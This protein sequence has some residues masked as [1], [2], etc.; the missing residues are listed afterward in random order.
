MLHFLSE[1]SDAR[2]YA[3]GGFHTGRAKLAPFFDVAEQEGLE[4]EFIQEE[5]VEGN[6]RP[7]MKER[8]GGSEDVTRRKRWL[9]TAR[10]KRRPK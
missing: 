8:D 9:V 4:V 2:V 3:I 5:D 10:L 6:V 7:W 1:E